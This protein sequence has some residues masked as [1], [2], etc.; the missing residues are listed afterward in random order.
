MEAYEPWHK[1]DRARSPVQGES[2]QKRLDCAE[3]R[4]KL[5]MRDME[6]R[7]RRVLGPNFGALLL[8]NFSRTRQT[9]A[10]SVHMPQRCP[11][12]GVL[13]SFS[14][15][16]LNT[17]K[18]PPAPLESAGAWQELRWGRRLL[19]RRILPR[20]PSLD[21]AVWATLVSPLPKTNKPA[22]IL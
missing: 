7:H 18:E 12:S 16:D 10:A 13:P 20:R 19:S 5:G 11:E 17:G 2:E 15:Y 3:K 21:Q 4:F 14:L 8:G 1:K 9:G 22:G 6:D